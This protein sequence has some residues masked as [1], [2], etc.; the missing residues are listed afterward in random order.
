MAEHV[1]H[2]LA[3]AGFPV[4]PRQVGTPTQFLERLFEG[5]GLPPAP[6]ESLL[7]LLLQEALEGLRPQRF[8]RVRESRGLHAELAGL[9]DELPEP[10]ACGEDLSAIFEDVQAR[11]ESRGFALRNRRLRFAA[12]L[13]RIGDIPT[14]PLTIFDGFFTLAGAEME[15]IETL[16]GRGSV[17]ITLP[18]ATATEETRRRLARAGFEETRLLRAPA[19]A[20]AGDFFRCDTG[21]RGRRDRAEDSGACG[22]GAEVPGHGRGA[23]LA[24]SI[25][26]A[27]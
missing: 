13:L 20:G 5:Q 7:H 11:L 14:P 9:L 22:A 3:R 23:P 27:G 10:A 18:Q 8:E 26:W 4:R 17:T 16:A 21:A 1:R 12:Q 2:Q 25:C 24:R 19:S 15:L 6:P